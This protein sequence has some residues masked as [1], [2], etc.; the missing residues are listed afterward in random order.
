[1]VDVCY[2]VLRLV[3]SSRAFGS[4]R[5]HLVL[6]SNTHILKIFHFDKNKSVE[7]FIFYFFNFKVFK[8]THTLKILFF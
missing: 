4:L 6:L 5:V 2:T 8:L 3:T 1:M 7:I